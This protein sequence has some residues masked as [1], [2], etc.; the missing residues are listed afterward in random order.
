MTR[1]ALPLAVLVDPGIGESAE[2]LKRFA[3]IDSFC[4]PTEPRYQV[5]ALAPGEKTTSVHI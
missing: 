2:V 4:K 1:N 5:P 3:L